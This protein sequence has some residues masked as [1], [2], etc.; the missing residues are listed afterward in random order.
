MSEAPKP[1][2]PMKEEPI[3]ASTSATMGAGALHGDSLARNVSAVG[4][5]DQPSP[6]DT[7]LKA[8]IRKAFDYPSVANIEHV[9]EVAASALRAALA[10]R[11]AENLE[12]RKSLG[13]CY[14]EAGADTDGNPDEV[15]APFAVEAVC[16]LRRDYD[17]AIHTDASQVAQLQ[18]KLDNAWT[19]YQHEVAQLQAQLRAKPSDEAIDYLEDALQ[20]AGF[21][22]GTSYG[23]AVNALNGHLAA[24][25]FRAEHAEASLLALRE[26]VKRL[27][28]NRGQVR[29]NRPDVF[30]NTCPLCAEELRAALAATQDEHGR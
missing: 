25:K 16:E 30:S 1:D 24:A 11:E 17:E 10:Q 5:S 18:T 2:A 20:N 8:A 9:A 13:R 22:E 26:K 21:P 23:L 4:T 29:H 3:D 19:S 12:L 15:N 14:R 7:P 6:P 27:V 28:L